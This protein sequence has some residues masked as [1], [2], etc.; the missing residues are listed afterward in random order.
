MHDLATP[1]FD[2]FV[3]NFIESQ[4]GLGAPFISGSDTI[5]RQLQRKFFLDDVFDTGDTAIFRDDKLQWI[6]AEIPNVIVEMRYWTPFAWTTDSSIL[7]WMNRTEV[8]ILS[9]DNVREMEM[10]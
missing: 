6:F 3:G 2:V 9:L 4:Y 1:F 10:S 5:R 7:N 8:L